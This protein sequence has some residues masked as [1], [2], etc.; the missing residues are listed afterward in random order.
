MASIN[1]LTCFSQLDNNASL[2]SLSIPFPLLAQNLCQVIFLSN[3][4]TCVDRM[5][6]SVSHVNTSSTSAISF[7]TWHSR[8]GHPNV[9]T[10][11]VV[12]KLCNIPFYH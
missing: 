8:L 12:F 5:C 4:A 11:K 7:A 6:P 9:D 3:S 10:I 1:S 2:F